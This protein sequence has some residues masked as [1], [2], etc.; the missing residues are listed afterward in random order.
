M[1]YKA[2]VTRR[3]EQVIEFEVE[4]DSG[5]SAY[6]K[7]QTL[8]EEGIIDHDFPFTIYNMDWYEDKLE[9]VEPINTQTKVSE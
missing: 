3:W 2:I 5:E 7:A 1:K 6:D 8:L 4:V 9:A